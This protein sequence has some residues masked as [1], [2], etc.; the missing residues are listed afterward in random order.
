MNPC[1]VEVP[2]GTQNLIL[3]TGKVAKQANASVLATLGGTSVTYGCS[4]LK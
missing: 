1:R 2:F 3:E 4:I